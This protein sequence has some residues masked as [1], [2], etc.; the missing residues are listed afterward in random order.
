MI[1][2][3]SPSKTLGII[4]NESL[5]YTTVPKFIGNSEELI[6]V[7]QNFSMNELKSLFSVSENIAQLNYARYRDWYTPFSSRNSTPAILTFKGDVYEGLGAAGFNQPDFEFAQQHL[8]IMSGLYGILRPLDLM[9]PYLLEMGTNL[10]VRESKNLYEF[11]SQ[12]ITDELNYELS[13]SQNPVLVNLAS[14]EYF[15]VIKQK[16]IKGTIITPVFKEQK[17][18]DFKVV[19]IYAKRARGLMSKFIV[20]HRI[21]DAEQLKQF[22]SEDYYY[23]SDM[24]TK[25]TMVFV[26]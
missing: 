7:L 10:E 9:Q 5:P 22:D 19:A 25:T 20:Q 17:G 1:T 16:N 26:R 24:S 6:N 14:Q 21:E 3:I 11:W 12:K 15:K 23:R 18:A 4:K 13:N 8:R 2:I